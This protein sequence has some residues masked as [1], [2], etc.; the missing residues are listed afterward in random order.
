MFSPLAT[1]LHG[2]ALGDFHEYEYGGHIIAST[3]LEEG[4]VMNMKEEAYISLML[5]QKKIWTTWRRSLYYRCHRLEWECYV[6]LLPSWGNPKSLLCFNNNLKFT[7]SLK[8][9]L[10]HLSV[11]IIDNFGVL[12]FEDL[13]VF[14]F[15]DF[16]FKTF[17]IS[18]A[19][20]WQLRSILTFMS[21]ETLTL[22]PENFKPW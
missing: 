7:Y 10:N 18:S 8:T 4:C 15:Y 9:L 11:N 2:F 21:W 20:L 14:N 1:F 17:M 3:N 16:K 6:S 13:R 5:T 22:W 19:E 12:N